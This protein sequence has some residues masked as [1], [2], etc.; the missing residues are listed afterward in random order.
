MLHG[1]DTFYSIPSIS[2]W[3]KNNVLNIND[4]IKPNNDINEINKIDNKKNKNSK[5]KTISLISVESNNG[6]GKTSLINRYVNN[7]FINDSFPVK[8]CFYIYRKKSR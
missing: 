8:K 4:L 7:Q 5:N 6:S 3:N 1:C 2:K